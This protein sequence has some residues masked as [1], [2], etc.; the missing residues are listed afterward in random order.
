MND[1]DL[2]RCPWVLFSKLLYNDEHH[3]LVEFQA[4]MV[5]GEAGRNETIIFSA[6]RI[7][8]PIPIPRCGGGQTKRLFSLERLTDISFSLAMKLSEEVY[9]LCSGSGAVKDDFVS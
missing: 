2:F 9:F 3:S 7:V 6:F 1:F 5:P 8:S 4:L